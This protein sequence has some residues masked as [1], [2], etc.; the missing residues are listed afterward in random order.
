MTDKERVLKLKN[1]FNDNRMSRILQYFRKTPV[2]TVGTLADKLEV[3]E[4]TIRNDIRQL[5]QELGSCGLIDGEK[6]KYS[7]HIY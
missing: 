3:S 6:G 1:L 4:R 2:I 5:N 7:L